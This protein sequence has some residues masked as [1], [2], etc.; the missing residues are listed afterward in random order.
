MHYFRKRFFNNSLYYHFRSREINF[1]TL[2]YRY[3]SFRR[4]SATQGLKITFKAVVKAG[5]LT[6][7]VIKNYIFFQYIGYRLMPY[8]YVCSSSVLDT[9]DINQN[10][11]KTDMLCV[12]LRRFNGIK[13]FGSSAFLVETHRD[14]GHIDFETHSNIENIDF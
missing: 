7:T 11:S 14:R 10:G 2:L 9:A 6:G 3:L 8:S 5:V 12:F 13:N 1:P 4:I